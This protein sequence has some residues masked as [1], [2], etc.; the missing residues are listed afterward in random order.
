ME[1][2]AIV[3]SSLI[4]M[5]LLLTGCEV[6]GDIFKTGVG[7]GVIIVVLIIVIGAYLFSKMRGRR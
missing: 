4:S 6:V 2:K 5:L 7:V 1:N 3:N